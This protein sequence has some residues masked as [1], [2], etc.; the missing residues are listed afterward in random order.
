[1]GKGHTTR[2]KKDLPAKNRGKKKKRFERVVV[3][4]VFL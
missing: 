3:V 4:W 2:R 1:M